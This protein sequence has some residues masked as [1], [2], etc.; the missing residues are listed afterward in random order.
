MA[1]ETCMY[2]PHGMPMRVWRTYGPSVDIWSAGVI[3]YELCS[4]FLPFQPVWYQDDSHPS[5]GQW[6]LNPMYQDI[7]AGSFSFPGDA[8][9]HISDSAKDL[10]A[11]MLFVNPSDRPTASALL[12]HPWMLEAAAATATPFPEVFAERFTKTRATYASRFFEMS[13]VAAARNQFMQQ[14]WSGLSVASE[15]TF[16]SSVAPAVD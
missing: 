12:Q 2:D 1:G 4:G 3:L 14:K 15:A 7:I 8:W 11:R 10:V 16:E 6:D 13:S 5:G 9:F